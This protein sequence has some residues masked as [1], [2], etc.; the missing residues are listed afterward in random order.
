MICV[1]TTDDYAMVAALAEDGVITSPR[2]NS[3]RLSFHCYNSEAD[4]DRMIAGLHKNA[5]LLAR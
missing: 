4:V 5:H 3:V 1:A 2:D